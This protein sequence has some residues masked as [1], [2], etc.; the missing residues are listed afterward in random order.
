MWFW[1]DRT[2]LSSSGV[3][4]MF[5]IRGTS[6]FLFI[7]SLSGLPWDSA[8]KEWWR[9]WHEPFLNPLWVGLLHVSYFLL[10]IFIYSLYSIVWHHRCQK[11]H[12]LCFQDLVDIS[13]DLSGMIYGCKNSLQSLALSA[14]PFAQ[15]GTV[16]TWPLPFFF[17][18]FLKKSLCGSLDIWTRQPNPSS[19]ASEL[20]M[21]KGK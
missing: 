17:L 14:F 13:W 12:G 21:P 6:P 16:P 3:A 1:G 7:F 10:W 15:F 11:R 8:D 2:S 20:N 4:L 18:F 5:P 9:L 19:R